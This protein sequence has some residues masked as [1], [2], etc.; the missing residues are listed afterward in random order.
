VQA[1]ERKS[2]RCELRFSL[3]Q[4]QAGQ[5]HPQIAAGRTR[6][7]LPASLSPARRCPAQRAGRTVS[8]PSPGHGTAK[9]HLLCSCARSQAAP[10]KCA[11]APPACR[12][13]E[14]LD[15]EPLKT[16]VRRAPCS[17][18]P[19][20]ARA[21]AAGAQARGRAGHHRGRPGRPERP[22]RSEA[23]GEPGAGQLAAHGRD[24]RLRRPVERPQHALLAAVRRARLPR[25]PGPGAALEEGVPAPSSLRAR[26][27]RAAG[28]AGSAAGR[29]P[30]DTVGAARGTRSQAI[31]AQ[32]ALD[33]LTYG[34]PCL[35]ASA[36]VLVSSA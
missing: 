11:S 34:A 26:R 21:A 36:R 27:L 17:A 24:G 15:K 22:D 32:V 7:G 13:L 1:R 28:P 23:S 31:C 20:V 33:Q 14:R 9:L 30:R 19:A 2:S 35:R 29:R 5:L 12:Y 10:S 25:R 4:G 3:L 6:S 16:K 18:A 8:W